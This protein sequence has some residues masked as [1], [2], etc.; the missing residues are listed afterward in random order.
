MAT[1]LKLLGGS[2][3]LLI[4]ILS[5]TGEFCS[6]RCG[7]EGGGGG[8]ADMCAGPTLLAVVVYTYIIPVSWE[9][10]DASLQV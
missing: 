4:S 7:D 9:M 1:F 5:T 2:L 6:I 10:S 3:R 8:L